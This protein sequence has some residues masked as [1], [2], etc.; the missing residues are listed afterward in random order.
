MICGLPLL[1]CAYRT[2]QEGQGKRV[3]E[4][5]DV[6]FDNISACGGEHCGGA[7]DHIVPVISVEIG[8]QVA[9]GG[10]E[11]PEAD[12]GG[13]VTNSDGSLIHHAKVGFFEAEEVIEERI[14]RAVNVRR[15]RNHAALVIEAVAVIAKIEN[16][17]VRGEESA[18]EAVRSAERSWTAQHD[19]SA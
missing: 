17:R 16:V 7:R 14:G 15:G 6:R 9:G 19:R 10:D 8:F 5:P 18:I 4:P 13:T 2:E 1:W 3:Q 12:R 11:L